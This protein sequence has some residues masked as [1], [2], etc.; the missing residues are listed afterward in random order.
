MVGAAFPRGLKHLYIPW[1][2]LAI[3]LGFIVSHV[4]LTLFFFL[5]LT[6]IGLAARLSGKDFLSLKL[7]PHASTY[8]L[9]HERKDPQSPDHYERQF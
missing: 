4:L 9:P 6:P 2:S 5:V 3:I 7:D 8:W 1:M